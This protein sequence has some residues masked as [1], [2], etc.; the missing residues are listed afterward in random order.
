MFC[1]I[2][3]DKFI[4]LAVVLRHLLRTRVVN[5]KAYVR[6]II[7]KTI[8]P[9][10]P[11]SIFA[12]LRFSLVVFFWSS[13]LP[14]CQLICEKCLCSNRAPSLGKSCRKGHGDHCLIVSRSI[15][16][17]A[18]GN[19]QPTGAGSPGRS[20]RAL[21]CSANGSKQKKMYCS[22]RKRKHQ[23]VRRFIHTSLT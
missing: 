6:I 16:S 1:L 3:L 2:S 14:R 4:S 15:C 22:F 7:V 11:I 8:T 10:G 5:I 18:G 23:R 12:S 9:H 20:R 21:L 19:P 13:S 17:T